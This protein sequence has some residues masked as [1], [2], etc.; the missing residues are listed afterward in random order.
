[1]LGL[2]FV[3]GRHFISVLELDFSKDA[4]ND[5]GETPVKLTSVSFG[6]F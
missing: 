5:C 3:F 6:S 4:R 2:N 1:M